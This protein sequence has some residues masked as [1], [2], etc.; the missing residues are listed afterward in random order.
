MCY[1]EI[2]HNSRPLN[3][4]H[5][6]P[7]LPSIP[8]PKKGSLAMPT[9]C[10]HQTKSGR[11]CLQ[12]RTSHPLLCTYHANQQHARAVHQGQSARRSPE[13]TAALAADLLQGVEN[14]SQPA[15]VNLFLGN[16][17]KQLVHRPIGRRDATT[18][19]YISQLLLNSQCVMQRQARDAQAAASAKPTQIIIDVERPNYDDDDGGYQSPSTHTLRATADTLTIPSTPGTPAPP[20]AH[21]AGPHPLHNSSSASLPQK[22]F[23]L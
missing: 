10:Q 7:R 18:L 6:Y 11:R 17:L 12:P 4:L 13:H 22:S 8:N 21:P 23:L 3:K 14:L 16:L 15:T 9:R 5:K 1:R 2:T 19:A 20:P